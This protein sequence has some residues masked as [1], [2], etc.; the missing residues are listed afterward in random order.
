[1][2]NSIR[3]VA[4]VGAGIAG[5]SA[6][7][8]LKR[9]GTDVCLVERNRVGGLIRNANLIENYPGFPRG[10]NGLAFAKL[11]GGQIEE[12]GIKIV[13][14]EV[15]SISYSDK[16]ALR[17]NHCV[18]NSK[19]CI[20]ATGT[21]AIIPEIEIDSMD[22]VY[23]E[24]SEIC[25]C[26]GK[27]ITIVGGGD[28]AFDYALN[29]SVRNRV[30]ILVRRQRSSALPLLVERVQSNSNIV[31]LN[32]MNP[33]K[34]VHNGNTLN[35]F[36]TKGNSIKEFQSDLVIFATGRIPALPEINI[37]YGT[38]GLFIVGDAANGAMRQCAI[39]SGDG[40][41]A[42]MQICDSLRCED[43]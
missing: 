21:Q 33:R 39:A 34:L 5:I 24:I 13:Q 27:C 2:S 26:S 17:T 16:F 9:F 18:I 4:I 19:Y 22:G 43:S 42:A 40:L 11:L 8:Q 29:L 10:I 7:I 12:H 35:I 20:V 31:V 28:A 37:P 30:T 14:S 15:E 32:G 41:R 36:C 6:A 3:E 25:D 38:N 1:M 23:S